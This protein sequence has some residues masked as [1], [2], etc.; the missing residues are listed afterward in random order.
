VA[1]EDEEDKAVHTRARAVVER[2]RDEGEER[3]RLKLGVGAG[4]SER[5][6]EREGRRCGLL[7][8]G[9]ITFYRGWGA[10]RRRWLGGNGWHY[11]INHH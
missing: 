5:E 10:P 6:L 7:R 4:E 8:G 2:R 1:G 3:W 9:V 11:G